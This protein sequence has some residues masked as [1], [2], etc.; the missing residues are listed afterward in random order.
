MRTRGARPF[1]HVCKYTISEE[2]S[3]GMLP[4]NVLHF[5]LPDIASGAFS[6]TNLVLSEC[7]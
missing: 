5:R 2:G 1:I 3:G 4:Q 6:G 7:L